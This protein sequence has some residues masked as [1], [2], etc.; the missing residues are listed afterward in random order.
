MTRSGPDFPPEDQPS[1]RDEAPE[2]SARELVDEA[3]PEIREIADEYGYEQLLEWA[4]AYVAMADPADVEGYLV[5][6]GEQIPT[7]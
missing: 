2:P 4:E 3:L 1:L 7:H 5:F 6:V